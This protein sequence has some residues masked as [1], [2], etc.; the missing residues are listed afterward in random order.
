MRSSG[1]A[2][3][4]LE[5]TDLA[6]SSRSMRFI[7]VEKSSARIEVE[8]STTR[9][10]STPSVSTR[11]S[12]MPFCGRAAATTRNTSPAA[13]SAGGSLRSA[14]HGERGRPSSAAPSEN[15]SGACRRRACRSQTSRGTS[16]RSSSTSGWRI[17]ITASPPRFRRA[18]SRGR[19]PWRNPAHC[20]CRLGRG[21]GG[22]ISPDRFAPEIRRPDSGARPIACER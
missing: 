17:V 14:S 10:M 1:R 11:D 22:R 21:R 19:G 3:M 16:S 18:W 8:V 4:N 20:A 2:R 13:N 15:V 12:L 9:T 6:A 7:A 5:M